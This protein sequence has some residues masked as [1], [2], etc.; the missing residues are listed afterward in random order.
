[1]SPHH[2][3]FLESDGE[4]VDEKCKKVEARCGWDFWSKLWGSG[5]GDLFCPMLQWRPV[6][7]WRARHGQSNW[8]WMLTEYWSQDDAWSISDF[9]LF[10]LCFPE[11]RAHRRHKAYFLSLVTRHAGPNEPLNN[12]T[13]CQPRLS[14]WRLS[15][16]RYIAPRSWND[17]LGLWTLCYASQLYNR[18]SSD[19]RHRLMQRLWLLPSLTE[20]H[21]HKFRSRSGLME[22]VFDHIQVDWQGSSPRSKPSHSVAKSL[23]AGPVDLRGPWANLRW[24]LTAASA[25][26][27]KMEKQTAEG[28]DDVDEKSCNDRRSRWS[29]RFWRNSYA[30]CGSRMRHVIRTWFRSWISVRQSGAAN[31]A[32]HHLP[33]LGWAILF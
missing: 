11:T 14:T 17:V 5:L 25:P 15:T 6:C 22:L 21:D 27:G 1:M 26:K 32:L 30:I 12:N 29:D 9:C 23:T 18:C 28:D 24:H 3:P 31:S 4:K 8:D 2:L 19:Q 16:F 13:R 20:P 33:G 7:L 10:W